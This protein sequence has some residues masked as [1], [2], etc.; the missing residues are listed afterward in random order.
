MAYVKEK[1]AVGDIKK[2]LTNKDYKDRVQKAESIMNNWRSL[3][4]EIGV[5]KNQSQLL[6]ACSMADMALAAKTLDI[7]LAGE[8]QYDRPEGLAHD[9]CLCLQGM[10]YQVATPWAEYQEAEPSSA[11]TGS[12][13]VFDPQLLL[14]EVSQDDGKIKNPAAVLSSAGFDI[15]CYV[16]RKA[17][18]IEGQ[19]QS[20]DPNGFVRIKLLSESR[21]AKMSSTALLKGEWQKFTPSSAPVII[22]NLKQHSIMK[23]DSWS[24]HV[25]TATI[26]IALESVGM[27]HE[28]HLSKLKL[29][30]RPTK[31]LVTTAKFPKGKL[32]LVPLTTS[33][34]P[35]T[36]VYDLVY[37]LLSWISCSMRIY[38]HHYMYNTILYI[39]Y[40]LYAWEMFNTL[41]IYII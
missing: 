23:H 27:K 2:A 39:I 22:E 7:K 13:Q 5:D 10:G 41:Y 18:G 28:E 12:G 19:L 36:H 26:I 15:G 4:N 35:K 33:V 38:M 8:R 20:V 25:A 40:I 37:T 11:S 21:V 31:V 9:F 30:L 16:K 29:Q 34:K 1:L 17:D 32:I 3:L 6:F 24:S 14:R